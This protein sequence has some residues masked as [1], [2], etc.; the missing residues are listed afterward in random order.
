[1]S[2]N[3]IVTL[4]T[5]SPPS[6]LADIEKLADAV[7]KSGMFG[8]RTRDQ[9]LVLM[10]ISQAEGRHPALAARD[11]DIIQ[12]R[13][14]KKAEAMLRDFLDSGGKVEWHALTDAVADATFSHPTG[15]TVRIV[16]DTAR[17]ITA[18]LG[19]KDMHKKYPRQMLRSR[20]VSEGVRTVCPMATSGMYVPEETRDMEMPLAQPE[21]INADLDQFAADPVPHRDIV[22]DEARLAADRGTEAFRDFWRDLSAGERDGIRE[23]LT[24][25]HTA[26][27]A[28]DD[29]FGLPSPTQQQPSQDAPAE[30]PGALPPAGTSTRQGEPS[31]DTVTDEALPNGANLVIPL[32]NRPTAEQLEYYAR[33][34]LAMI[35]E[36]P[37]T[38]Q[39]AT[40]IKDKNE[41]GIGFLKLKLVERYDE[42]M[43]ALNARVEA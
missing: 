15:G 8:I 43:R 35:A 12:G 24:A 21:N 31:P 18:G 4:P 16:W 39:R 19:A 17:A 36:R 6:S 22:L 13:P 7:A 3:E 1:M 38:A 34:L 11:Y 26:A 5:R 25:F 27:T 29:P 28:A 42:V 2:T 10:A 37:L 30:H 41:G 20:C 32:P 40:W 14:A 23:H 9:A 33:Q